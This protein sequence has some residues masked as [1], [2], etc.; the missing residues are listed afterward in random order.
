VLAAA[1]FYFMCPET[2]GRPLEEI[3]EVFSRGWRARLRSPAAAVELPVS[4]ARDGK[5]RP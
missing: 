4:N 2:Q 1:F 5:P 3:E